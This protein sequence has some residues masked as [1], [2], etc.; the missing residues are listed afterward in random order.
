[1]MSQ[2]FSATATRDPVAELYSYKSGRRTMNAATIKYLSPTGRSMSIDVVDR[3]FAAILRHAQA[4]AARP[5]IKSVRVWSQGG[6]LL[7]SLT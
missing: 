1:M 7:A 2:A 4:I 6:T 3:D 5:G